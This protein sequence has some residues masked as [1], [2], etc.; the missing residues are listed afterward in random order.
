MPSSDIVGRIAIIKSEANGKQKTKA[1]KLREA[2]ILLKRP[3]IKTVLEKS[4][5]VKG[6]LRK[7]QTK[8]ILGEKNKT[9]KYKENDCAFKLNVDTC[10]FSPRLSDERNQIS[11]LIKKKDSVLVMFSG[12]SVYPIVIEK[13]SNPKKII[14]IEISKECNKYAKENLK[15]NH[16]KKIELIQGDVKKKITKKLGKFDKIIMARPNLE[17]TFLESALKASKKGTKILY[18]GFCNKDK[19]KEMKKQLIDEANNLKRKIKITKTKKSGD[20]A[21]YKFRYRLHINV[22][23]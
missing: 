8:H 11:R 3:S 22:L 23:N 1:Q 20:I 19:L 16:S 17:P 21:P 14:A 18:Y 10:Y 15:L 13:K 9:T 7:I 6:R 5:N 4:S 12:I 2:K